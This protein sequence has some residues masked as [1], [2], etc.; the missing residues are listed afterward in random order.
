MKS[1]T[2]TILTSETVFRGHPD[3]TCDQIS[4]GILDA[5]LIQDK[6]SHVAIECLIK[7]DLLIIAGEVTTNAKINYSQVAREILKEIGGNG[8]FNILERYLNKVVILRLV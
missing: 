5:C 4:N 7:D 1:M 3:K 8:S 6:N 2:M